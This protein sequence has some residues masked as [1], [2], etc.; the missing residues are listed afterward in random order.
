MP[1]TILPV[2][3]VHYATFGCEDTLFQSLSGEEGTSCGFELAADLPA[4]EDD[5]ELW[6][7]CPQCG[8]RMQVLSPLVP[9]TA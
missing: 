8:T 4:F 1:R 3:R 9:R 2:P 6:P 5:P 7:V